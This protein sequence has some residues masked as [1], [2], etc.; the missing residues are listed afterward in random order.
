MAPCT[1]L[2]GRRVLRRVRGWTLL[3]LQGLLVLILML[4]WGL[5]VAL[6]LVLVLMLLYD[7][8]VYRID[9]LLMCRI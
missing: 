9:G 6:V 8:A 3:L 2:L 4:K 1:M 5:T 7:R